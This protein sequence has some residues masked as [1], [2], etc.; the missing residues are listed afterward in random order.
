MSLQPGA[1]LGPYEIV[2]LIGEGGMGQVFRARDTKLAREVAIKIL[3]PLFAEDPERLARFE[4]EARTLAALNHPNIAH[5]HGM[6]SD[7]RVHALVMELVDG[8]DLSARI[9]RGPIPVG[10]AIAAA[11]QIADALEA[12]HEHGI[13]H[14]DL[15]PANIKIRDDAVVKLLD[16]G[17][18]KAWTHETAGGDPANS[19]TL[20]ARAT[21]LG[22]IL[23]TAA[24][25][26]PEQARGKNVDRRADIWAFGVVLF[27]MLTA[28]RAFPGD[29]VTDVLAKVIEREP[30]LSRLP[31]ST[32]P[33]LRRLIARCLIKDPKLRL[34][35]IG[36]ARLAL[37]DAQQELAAGVPPARAQ[38]ERAVTV[39]LWRR[40]L[41][42]VAALGIVTVLA[43]AFRPRPAASAGPLMRL[44]ISLPPGVEVYSAVG[45]ALTISPDGSLLAFAGVRQGV[46]QVFLRRLDSYEITPVRGTETAVSCVF[47]PDGRE[48]LVGMSD[49]SL[50]RVRLSDGLVQVVTSSTSVYFGGWLSNDRA[51]FSKDGRLWMTDGTPGAMPVQL[52]E[53]QADPT[54]IDVQSVPVP[55]REALLF[56]S[57]RPEAADQARIESLS[58][59]DRVRKTVIERA[60][61]PLVTAGRLL[62]L[63]NR[64]VFSAPFDAATLTITGDPVP[65]L[66]DVS[67]VQ[68]R[69][70]SPILSVS[71]TGILVYSSTSSVQSEIVSVSRQ[72]AERTLL[73]LDMPIINPRIAGAGR[74]L[75]LEQLGSGLWVQDLERGALSRLTEAV[76]AAGFPILAPDGQ[77]AVYRTLPGMSTVRVDG[78]G[79]AAAIEGS[80][81][82]EFPSAITP[83]GKD[84]LYTKITPT[85]AGDLYVLPLAGGKPRVLLST[86]AYEGGAE[87]SPD[88]RWI[89]YVSNERGTS[90]IYLQPYPAMDRRIQV[91]TS[92]GIHPRWNPT[93]G[94]I[95]YR[96]GERV[97][98]VRITTTAAG[99]SLSEPVPLFSGRY[100]FGGGLTIPNYS[101]TADGNH[102]IL[103][104]ERSGATLNVV[105]NWL[106]GIERGER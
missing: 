66:R 15:K 58:L 105:L 74:W 70:I 98:S 60:T 29:D 89:V 9:A 94:E 24:Y 46:R 36:E 61:N 44:Q 18:A 22:T 28:S 86:P 71:D 53:A 32:P 4:R 6:E 42:W 23:G 50:R 95:F 11:Q 16:F 73:T 14:R 54:S 64:V 30:D 62:F 49:T 26:A 99:P 101:V 104:K 33:T 90:E 55:G 103:V 34:R 21:Q 67:I 87:V 38:V 20:T 40:A 37:V 65:V 88:G 41:P 80:G 2:S 77:R 85:T 93:G 59:P 84:L 72:G 17:L 31:A 5:I 57:G 25:M 91:S 83:D 52:T 27:E 100:A 48:L 78:G 51:V 97:M 81:D 56:T 96:T 3:P 82:S 102:F 8:E 12:A 47:S 39:S 69:G 1:R 92:G 63:R 43:L 79:K 68:N 45:A 19:P 13:V 75:I 7:E 76:E 106:A 35:D 10:E